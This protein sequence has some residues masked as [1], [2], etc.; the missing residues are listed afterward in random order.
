LRDAL[1]FRLA[2]R[3]MSIWMRQSES[4]R[5]QFGSQVLEI[6]RNSIA[7]EKPT[8]GQFQLVEFF[9]VQATTGGVVG[10]KRP[11]ERAPRATA[12]GMFGIPLANAQQAASRATPL[13][14]QRSYVVV[15]SALGAVAVSEAARLRVGVHSSVSFRG[16]KTLAREKAE[17]IAIARAELAKHAPPIDF[18][19][20]FDSLDVL[21]RIVRHFY[22]RGLIEE[23]MGV[24]ADWKAVGRRSMRLS[25]R[26]RRVL[27]DCDICV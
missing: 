27:P 20:T 11:D 19:A 1:R 6:F 18:T 23:S 9:A 2:L 16:R 17:K 14:V 26:R 7:A 8:G 24:D 12:W 22:L 5:Q 4:R 21:E 15:F 10:F 25:S 3:R 13:A